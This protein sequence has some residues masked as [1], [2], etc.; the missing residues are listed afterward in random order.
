MEEWISKVESDLQNIMKEKDTLYILCPYHIG[1][2]IVN[3][4]LA[5]ATAIRKGKSRVQI[6]ALERLNSLGLV[7]RDVERILYTTQ[8]SMNTLIYYTY[9]TKRYEAD[10]FIY[11][12]FKMSEDHHFIMDKD[13]NFIENYK[14]HVFSLPLDAPFV[15]PAIIKPSEEEIAKLSTDFIIDKDRTILLSPYNN[16][17]PNLKDELW[18]EIAKRLTEKGF[19]VYTNVAPKG[20]EPIA[21]TRP[22]Q[23]SFTALF[24]LAEKMRAVV[25]YR[26]GLFDYL[27]FTKANLLCIGKFP[28]WS[29]NLK[30]LFPN[31]NSQMFYYASDFIAP[32]Y[33]YLAQNETQAQIKLHHPKISEPIYLSQE[34]IV[35]AIISAIIYNSRDC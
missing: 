9:A 12:H 11:G 22:F 3:G 32:V 1:D 28:S 13:L 18:E 27:A 2:L 7:F 15:S 34:E 25:G 23:A 26:S 33:E 10:N 35:R 4:C 21:G 31:S 8:E 30:L 20:E 14:R 17:N 5:H 16:S 19:I 29:Y 6:I 24:F